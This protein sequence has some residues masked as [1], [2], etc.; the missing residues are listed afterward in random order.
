[1]ESL[2]EP[3]EVVVTHG[4][5]ETSRTTTAGPGSCQRVTSSVLLRDA[6]KQKIK[7]KKTP[8]GRSF[9]LRK[10]SN[11][12]EKKKQKDVEDSQRL[13]PEFVSACGSRTVTQ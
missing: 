4:V 7:I 2:V 8:R 13:S 10:C 9:F 6:D 3:D 12:E 11:W 1:M 5:E